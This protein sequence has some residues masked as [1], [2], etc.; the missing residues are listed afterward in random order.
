MW[1]T[2][3]RGRLSTVATWKSADDRGTH[4]SVRDTH[5]FVAHC[6]AGP[7]PLLLHGFPQTHLCWEQV[8]AELAEAYQL[9]APDLRGYGAT[10]AQAG[11]PQG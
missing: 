4:V 6:G 5:Y 3:S 11:G 2:R 7:P 10:T 1:W 9:V 8:A